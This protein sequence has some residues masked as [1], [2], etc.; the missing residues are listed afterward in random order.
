MVGGDPICQ[1]VR[2]AG[3]LS[4][5]P[6]NR[7]GA[8]A[9][10]IGSEKISVSFHCAGDLEIYH[11]RLHHCAFVLEVD[12]EDGIHARE[13]NHNA[14]L[15][16]DRPSRQ[17]RAGP[18]SYEGHV[19]LVRDLHDSGHVFG[20][21]GK[22]HNIRPMLID[23]TVVLVEREVFRPVEASPPSQQRH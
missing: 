3:I 4:D 5:V 17:P 21:A 12:F 2:S 14:A 23:S 7:A 22:H 19:E 8:L 15:P 16:R 1:S 9:R 11:A 13:G 6:A 18:A 20:V 10:R